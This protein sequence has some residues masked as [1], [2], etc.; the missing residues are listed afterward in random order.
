MSYFS[1]GPGM[2]GNYGWMSS[3]FFLMPILLIWTL[4]WKALALWHS[5]KRDQAWWFLAILVFNTM[6]ILEIIYLFGVL[7]LK[8]EQLIPKLKK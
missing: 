7:K 5:A 3:F 4:F 8:S 1:Y 2:M 6:G